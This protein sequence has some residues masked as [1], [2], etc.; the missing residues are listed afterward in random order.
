MQAV[1]VTNLAKRYRLYHR[2]LDRFRDWLHGG[3]RSYH[4]DFFALRNVTF[5]V[6]PGETVGI[7]GRNGSGKSTLL[8]LIAGILT[9]TEGTVRVQGRLAALLELGVGFN[10]ELTGLENYYFSGAIMGF[11]RRELDARRDAVTAF[12]DI[13]DYLDQ[14]VKTYSSGMFVR[15]A[16]AVAVTV[17][18][19]ILIVDEALAVGDLNFQARCFRRLDEFRSA[20]KTILLV[21]HALDSVLRYASRALLLDKGRLLLDADPKEGVDAYKQLLAHCYD[22]APPGP[23]PAARLAGA[24]RDA[25]VYGNGR[26]EITD[27]AL[28]DEHGSPVPF[29]QHG[30]RFRVRMTVRFHDRVRDPIFAFTIKDL[31]GMEITGTNTRFKQVATGD[32]RAGECREVRFSQVWPGAPGSYALS[33]GCTGYEGDAMLV[34]HRLYDI[35]LFESVSDKPMVGWY[36]LNSEIEVQPAG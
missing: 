32:C 27:F 15:L 10:P 13:G 18:P 22:A 30:R 8:K 35:L 29:L 33:L 26:A 4:Q 23:E 36:D 20:G 28:E 6:R 21:T 5:A 1:T 9:P 31:K 17:D 34:Y 12:A 3:R 11:S 2:P 7:I 24:N 14:P 19:D 16:F 25:R